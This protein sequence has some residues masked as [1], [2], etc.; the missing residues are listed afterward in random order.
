M[1]GFLSILSLKMDLKL[2]KNYRRKLQVG[3]C[4]GLT[5]SFII[6]TRS[7]DHLHTG[8]LE[9]QRYLRGLTIMLNRDMAHHHFL[10]PCPVRNTTGQK[11]KDL[12]RTDV[13]R[14]ALQSL[15]SVK[16]G[17]EL[18]TSIQLSFKSFFKDVWICGWLQLERM[19]SK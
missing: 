6:P 7:L 4:H 1:A 11:L 5:A 14:L 13:K 19:Y 18:S 3:I 15:I 10:L 17:Q 9:E 8:E 12:L 16:V 2:W